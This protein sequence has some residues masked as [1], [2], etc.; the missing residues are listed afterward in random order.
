MKLWEELISKCPPPGGSFFGSKTEGLVEREQEARNLT[1][2]M[3]D[4]KPF[5]FLRLGDMELRLLL[6]LQENRFEDLDE[7][8]ISDGPL[9]GTERIGNPGL[10][11]DHLNRLLSAYE[12]ADYVDF[13]EANWPNEHLVPLLKLRRGNITHRNPSKKTSLVF[14]SWLENEFKSFCENRRVGFAGAEVA[15]LER[16]SKRKEFI[17]MADQFWARSAEYSFHQIRDNGRNLD[18][19]LNIIKEDLRAFVL[20]NRL[21]TLFLSLG[22]GAKIIGYELSRELGI[23]CFDFGAL[24]RA[25]TYSGCDGNRFSRSPHYPFL[26]RL[27][28]STY[29]D[30]LEQAM[31][32]MSAEEVLAKAHGQLIQEIVKKEVGWSHASKE[33][34]FCSQNIAAFR[35]S[36]RCYNKRYKKLFNVS[37]ASKKERAGFLHFCGTHGLTLRGRFFLIWFHVKGVV[38]SLL[39]RFRR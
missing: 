35:Q 10:G 15:I 19:N 25:L 6:S 9:S 7:I 29:M 2:L 12:G 21:D 24:T 13:H 14:F 27:S 3:L 8:N 17:A 33:Y 37:P 18:K 36:L 11:R 38:A 4:R 28:F 31:P 30:C 32:A 20:I 39:K 5:C 22:G 34:D 1:K 26:Y 23:R 16:L